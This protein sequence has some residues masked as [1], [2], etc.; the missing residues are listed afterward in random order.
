MLERGLTFV[1]TPKF[2]PNK[3]RLQ[4]EFDAQ[5]YHRRIELALYFKDGKRKYDKTK[6]SHRFTLPSVWR[7]PKD[8]LPPEMAH[9]IKADLDVVKHLDLEI[10]F[11]PNITAEEKKEL[12]RLKTN[13]NIVIKASDKGNAVVIMDR[14]QYV[15]EANRQLSDP[16]YYKPLKKPIYPLVR[17]VV[18]SIIQGLFDKKFIS[19]KQKTYLMNPIEPRVRKFYTLPKIHKEQSKWTKPGEIPAARPIVSD[20]SSETYGTAEYLDFYLTP[21]SQKHDSYVKDTSHFISL[22]KQLDVPPDSLFFTIDVDSLYTNIPIPEGIDAVREIFRRYPDPTRPDTELIQLLYINLTK[23]DFVFDKKYYLQVTGTAMGKRFAPS[24]ANIFMAQWEKA[25][26]ATCPLKP[27]IY[28]RYLDDIFGIWTHSEQEFQAFIKILDSFNPA[29]RIKHTQSLQEVDFLDTTVYKGAQFRTT[30]KVDVKV[31]FKPTDSHALLHRTSFHPRNT[32]KAI[33]KSQLIRFHRICTEKIEFYRATR[34]LFKAL[35]TR[36]YGRSYLRTVFNTFLQKKTSQ[37]G[38]I[39]PIVTT[40][41][42]VSHIL[43]PKLKKNYFSYI[44]S[45]GLLPKHSTINAFKKNSNLKD[46]L[47]RA[48]LTEPQVRDKSNVLTQQRTFQRLRLVKSNASK[49]VYDIPQTFSPNTDNCVYLIYC[50]KCSLQYVGETGSQLKIRYQQHRYNFKRGKKLETPLV[51]HFFLLH[52]P[53][54]AKVAGLESCSTWTTQERRKAELSW[55]RKLKTRQPYGLNI[56]S[57][58]FPKQT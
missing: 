45:Q 34:I 9:L 56:K 4:L 47:V 46:I 19:A 6:L 14:E 15:F 24:Y 33:V 49:L 25:V 23:N 13:Q 21:L 2:N 20:C 26:L 29:I 54:A 16:H 22:V 18:H 43:H 50:E 31:F 1:P 12:L 37:E 30:G 53:H 44:T 57:R 36:G 10:P 55:I 7:P 39:L 58:C 11:Q 41:S 27:I 17:P 32:C 48:T 28:L 8:K 3:H 52:G 42:K 38:D 5:Q 40:Y 51:R 35:R